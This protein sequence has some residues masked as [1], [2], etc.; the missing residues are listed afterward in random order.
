MILILV[1]SSGL[2]SYLWIQT[3]THPQV[4]KFSM[5]SYLVH[6]F[7]NAEE[8][9]FQRRKRLFVVD[10][11]SQRVIQHFLKCRGNIHKRRSNFRLNWFIE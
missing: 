6:N 1:S 4:Y 9:G 7:S 3:L 2:D 11:H 5:A 10:L 8:W